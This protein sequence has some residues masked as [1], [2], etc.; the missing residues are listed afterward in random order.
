M[1][2]WIT[3]KDLMER[4]LQRE[5]AEAVNNTNFLIF[6]PRIQCTIPHERLL[7]VYGVFLSLG[8]LK[9]VGLTDEPDSLGAHEGFKNFLLRSPKVIEFIITIIKSDLTSLETTLFVIAPEEVE[10]GNITTFCDV[11]EDLFHYRINMYPKPAGGPFGD[12]MKCV[13]YYETETDKA[14]IKGL[15]TARKLAVLETKSKK[16]IRRMIV[17]SGLYYKGM[18]KEEMIELI[19]NGDV[20]LD[21]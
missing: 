9:G 19:V 7:N 6:S 14:L 10:D 8:V 5:G 2:Y 21:E 16:Q 11:I 4:Y 17:D 1:I 15:P 12:C 13:N 20:R 3:T 18:P